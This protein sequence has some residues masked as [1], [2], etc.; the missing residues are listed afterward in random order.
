M[1]GLFARLNPQIQSMIGGG[2]QGG[3]PGS[4]PGP[5]SMTGG[6]LQGGPGW[7]MA[8]VPQFPT[9]GKPGW[10]TPSGT[11][12]GGDMVDRPI[13]GSAGGGWDPATEAWLQ[14]NSP[15]FR[16]PAPQAP[17]ADPWFSGG[18]VATGSGGMAGMLGNHMAMVPR[19]TGQLQI[20]QPEQPQ[21]RPEIQARPLQ[22]AQPRPMPSS[23]LRAPQ[24]TPTARPVAQQRPLAPGGAAG[25]GYNTQGQYITPGRPRPVKR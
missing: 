23:G 2:F 9:G 21:Q 12:W 7:G 24:P 17:Q 22:P 11:E 15:G 25:F 13:S 1:A 4:A 16:P 8:P 14:Q 3:G 19:P 5:Q 6:G 10:P 18:Q 20:Q